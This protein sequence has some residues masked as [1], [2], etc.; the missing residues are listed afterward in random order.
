[1]NIKDVIKSV[2]NY[3]SEKFA[4]KVD[5][6]IIKLYKLKA[7]A[8]VVEGITNVYNM[9]S[10]KDGAYLTYDIN[11]NQSLPQGVDISFTIDS[12]IE[13]THTLAYLDGGYSVID[14]LDSIED[15]KLGSMRNGKLEITAS[16]KQK[17]VFQVLG[18]K[19]ANEYYEKSMDMGLFS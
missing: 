10:R 13:D 18:E 2:H 11:Y 5:A 19:L 9:V 6:Q 4:E 14:F 1:M 15:H 17:M 8:Q 7:M 16:L 12:G 3:E